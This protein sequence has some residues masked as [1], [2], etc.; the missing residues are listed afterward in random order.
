[1]RVWMHIKHLSLW[2]GIIATIWAAFHMKG[3]QSVPASDP[4]T[5]LLEMMDAK[6]SRLEKGIQTGLEAKLSSLP[7]DV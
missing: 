7:T 6:L 3:S 4:Q 1:M 2:T 5:Q